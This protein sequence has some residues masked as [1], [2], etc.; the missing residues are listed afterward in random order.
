[1]RLGTDI[2]GTFTDIVALDDTVRHMHIAK[3]LTTPDRPDDAVVDGSL[4]ALEKAARPMGSVTEFLHGTTLFTNALIERRGAK[5]ALVTT[6]GFRDVIEIAREH[7]FDMYDLYMTRPAP[8]APRPLRFEVAERVA[9][10]GSVIAPLPED[11][12]R[13]VAEALKREGVEAVAVC[14]LNAYANG[15]HE[16]AAGELLRAALPEVAITLS[17]DLVPEIR[18]VERTSTALANVYVQAIA[19]RYLGRLQE[20]LAAEGLAGKMLI[21]QSNGGLCDVATAARYPIRL[22]ESGPAGG[23]IAAARFGA[24]L[25]IDNLLSFDMGGTTAK[26]CL[27][28]DGEPLIA[29]DF[30]VDRQYRFTKGSGL[31]IQVPVIEMI[32]IGTGGGSIAGL[33]AVGRMTVGP[34]SAGSKPGPAAYGLGGDKPTVTDADLV[35]GYLDPDF[36]LGGTMDLDMDGARRAIDAE[37]GAPLGL[38]TVAAAAGIYRIANESM[39]SSA[40]I[41]GIERGCDLEKFPVFA[42]GGAGPVHAYGVASIL[43]SPRIVYPPSAGVMSAL[44][45][46]VAPIS[47]DVVQS[48]PGAMTEM[49]WASVNALI[50]RMR[51]ETRDQI[52]GAVPAERVGF[53]VFADMRY[54]GQGF[55]VRVELPAGPLG[56]DSVAAIRERFET[57]YRQLYGHLVPNAAIEFVSWRVIAS[58]PPPA[59]ALPSLPEGAGDASV[60]RKGERQIYI[61]SEDGF[62][63]AAVYDRYALPAG[64][65]FEGPA[66]VEERESTAVINGPGRAT[67]DKVGNLILDLDW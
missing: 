59:L 54:R 66:I 62:R 45:F 19:E 26:A 14:F 1:M 30:E 23:A 51:G 6:K 40:R 52:V 58:G 28:K 36:F 53:R 43:R 5:T 48:L 32:E 13:A 17:S 31:P 67:V 24:S 57:V 33:D 37:I 44:G 2:G 49:N 8:L 39:A 29:P 27:I 61:P 21:M 7:R 50:E 42:Y 60:A 65:V 38:D 47:F 3:V 55:E 34:R 11:E 12:V 41:H 56:P 20:R 25:G 9:A 35:L 18:E 16:A 4:R 10:D 22:V 63:T 64:A 15:T 46:L